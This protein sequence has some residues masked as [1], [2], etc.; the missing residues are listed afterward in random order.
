[1]IMIIVDFEIYRKPK[2]KNS[3]PNV[4]LE[5]TIRQLHIIHLHLSTKCSAVTRHLAITM[6]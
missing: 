4:N 5:K 6:S 1:M 3:M 2:E